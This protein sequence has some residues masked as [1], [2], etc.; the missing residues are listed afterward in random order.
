MAEADFMTDLDRR[1]TGRIGMEKDGL[2][3]QAQVA[4]A[5]TSEPR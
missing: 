3:S 4:G 5:S 1:V 2:A